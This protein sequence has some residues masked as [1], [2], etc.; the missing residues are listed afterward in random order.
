MIN[1]FAHRAPWEDTPDFPFHPPKKREDTPDFPF[2]PP[3]KKGIPFE[4]VGEGP[5]GIFQGYVMVCGW[6]LRYN[7]TTF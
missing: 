3:K 2:H 5:L 7:Q 4:T 1:D 6:D